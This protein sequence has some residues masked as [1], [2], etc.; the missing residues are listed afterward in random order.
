M[1]KL[2]FKRKTYGWGWTPSSWQGWLTLIIWSLVMIILFT[3]IDI[4]SHSASDTLYAFA[5]PALIL[6]AIIW[7]I[8]WL[9]G[10]KPRWQWGKRN[11][12]PKLLKSA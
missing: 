1:S 9:K 4:N 2:W 7:I 11:K 8:C 12:Q 10:E 6:T 5:I 3:T